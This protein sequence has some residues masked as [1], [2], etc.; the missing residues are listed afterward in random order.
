MGKF[1]RQPTLQQLQAV[2]HNTLSGHLGIVYTA[3]G[4]D[5]IEA[6][7]PVDARTKQPFGLLHGG[8]TVALAETLGSTA[9]HLCVD[10]EKFRCVGIEINANHIRSATEGFVIGRAT[11]V[12]IGRGTQ[13][14]DIKIR[15]E[16]DQIVS[17]VRL[18][19]MVKNRS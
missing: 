9:A 14:W 17:V 18:T 6:K 8:A 3:V 15:N 13:V 16:A 7:M 12:H 19:V 2:D 10:L 4:E 1:V 5:F 11:P